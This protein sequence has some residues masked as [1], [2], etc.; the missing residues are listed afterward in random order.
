MAGV[1]PDQQRE[2]DAI[3]MDV[4]SARDRWLDR[5]DP[6][7]VATRPWLY[8][9]TPPY[10]ADA[11]CYYCRANDDRQLNWCSFCIHNPDAVIYEQT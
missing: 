6:E 2:L 4:R 3:G 9:K 1:T 8:P 11:P 10:P 7:Q 5:Q